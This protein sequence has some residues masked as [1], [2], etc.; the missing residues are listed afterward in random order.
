MGVLTHMFAPVPG[1]WETIHA[2][3]VTD[4]DSRGGRKYVG[5]DSI[6]R[7]SESGSQQATILHSFGTAKW[8]EEIRTT[9]VPFW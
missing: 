5:R 4:S 9:V 3:S 2:L 8:I 1:R 6:D 7:E